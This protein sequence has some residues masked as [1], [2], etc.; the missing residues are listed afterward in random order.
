MST[1]LSHWKQ[2]FK[3]ALT[4]SLT[5]QQIFSDDGIEQH[6]R[7]AG[8]RWRES[9]WSPAITLRTCILQ[10]LGA[11]KSLR[12]AVSELLCELARENAESLLPS[13][14]PSALAQARQRLPE[15][16]F[17]SV[18]AQVT[19]HVRSLAGHDDLWHGRRVI[20]IDGS[21]VSMPDTPELQQAFPQPPGQK[22]GCG[23]PVAYLVAFFCWHSGAALEFKL[24]SQHDGEASMFRSML[25]HVQPGMVTVADRY[26]CSYV[27]IVRLTQRGASVVF[28]QHQRR[29]QD[30]RQGKRLGKDDRL[31]TWTRPGQWI[32][33]FGISREEFLK[34]PETM[35]LRM[36]RT[37][38]T[39]KGF[40]SRQIV[41]VTS[42]LDPKEVSSDELLAL[43]RDRWIVELNLRSL[44]ITLDMDILR[45]KS[46]DVVRKE[47]LV[48][49]LV[50]N[51]IRLLMWEAAQAL[52]RN[53][54]RLSFAGTLHRL[55]RVASSLFLNDRL[56]NHTHDLLTAL[57]HWIASD[58]LPDRPD[59]HEPRRVKR[60]PKQYSLLSKPRARYHRHADLTCR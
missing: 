50:Y 41:I 46:V 35:T 33:S 38:K 11:V 48:H 60:R 12:A 39:P 25:H 27:D 49:L 9:F 42:I 45:G 55:Q 16:V 19:Q 57:L 14:D 29:S 15:S 26:Y 24:G 40:R 5:F 53:P 6:C 28:R 36:I 32:P 17:E 31:V 13:A 52:G 44:K 22:P 3:S 23:F 8:H 4:R 10:A 21:N 7:Q 59:R 58:V 37:A 2:Q 34:L 54:R 51:L 18:L 30:F 1:S 43:Y 47:I 20:L 56:W